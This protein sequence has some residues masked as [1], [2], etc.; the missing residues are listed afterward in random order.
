[1]PESKLG[2]L[3]GSFFVFTNLEQNNFLKEKSTLTLY[4]NK[5]E[6]EQN[7][8]KKLNIDLR[9][10]E[11]CQKFNN[12]KQDYH[13]LVF[14][15]QKQFMPGF[16]VIAITNFKDES[17]WVSGIIKKMLGKK[18]KVLIEG[19]EKVEI[20]PKNQVRLIDSETIKIAKNC[21][22]LGL[23]EGIIQAKPIM[24]R[25][26]AV[27]LKSKI[28][29][30]NIGNKKITFK[31]FKNL[32]KRI[33]E[34]IRHVNLK[35]MKIIRMK[36]VR[37]KNDIYLNMILKAFDKKKYIDHKSLVSITGESWSF[38]KKIV[39]RC[40]NYI[41]NNSYEKKF[42]LKENYRIVHKHV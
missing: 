39:E 15:S 8:P 14:E 29:K 40:C 9:S 33:E 25:K 28:F 27:W 35:S 23:L 36:R 32:K 3:E 26:Y 20:F 19:S 4:R 21:N 38:L 1:M 37:Q 11:K 16:K 30:S 24:N 31:V 6:K 22:I 2:L 34:R 42:T 10:N 13:Q 17:K 12:G 41:E 7:F 18:L 5:L